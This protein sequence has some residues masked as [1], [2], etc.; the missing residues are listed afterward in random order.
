M[1]R[2]F[3]AILVSSLLVSLPLTGCKGLMKGS[4]EMKAEDFSFTD[5]SCIKVDGPFE[6]DIAYADSY[7]VSITVT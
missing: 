5:F 7:H 2:L 6:V 4:G 1:K 3:I